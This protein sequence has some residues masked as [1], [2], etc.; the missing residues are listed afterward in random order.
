MCSTSLAGFLGWRYTNTPSLV[1]D[2]VTTALKSD[3]IRLGAVN[4]VPRNGDGGH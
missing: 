1:K 3:A 4:A 2:Q